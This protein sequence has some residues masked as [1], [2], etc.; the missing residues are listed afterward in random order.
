M[1]YLSNPIA[2]ITSQSTHIRLH[3]KWESTHTSA[4]TIP[5]RDYHFALHIFHSEIMPLS[6]PPPDLKFEPST[7]NCYK[8][9]LVHSVKSFRCPMKLQVC[10]EF[11]KTTWLYSVPLPHTSKMLRSGE[12][13]LWTEMG[14]C[15]AW[16][17][18]AQRVTCL[19]ALESPA[20]AFPH[21]LSPS[22]SSL[23]YVKI[24][25]SKY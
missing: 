5:F 19:E 25:T 8:M 24:K 16:Q 4:H 22:L 17:P 23:H 9:F 7:S 12:A 3:T 18:C 20:L 2:C 1:C 14:Y 15:S 21:P 6:C 11:T 13:P 10:S